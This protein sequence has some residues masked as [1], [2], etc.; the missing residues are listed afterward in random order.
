MTGGKTK[1]KKANLLG[2]SKKPLQVQMQYPQPCALFCIILGCSNSISS[3]RKRE[4]EREREGKVKVAVGRE[5]LSISMVLSL[6]DCCYCC[7][8]SCIVI[9]NVCCVCALALLDEFLCPHCVFS[10]FFFCGSVILFLP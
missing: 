4:R 2:L 1:N 8:S 3:I 6:S 7:S 5:P 9:P 10:F